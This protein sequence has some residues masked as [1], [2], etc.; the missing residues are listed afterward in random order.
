[1]CFLIGVVNTLPPTLAPTYVA[2]APTPGPTI[3]PSTMP[4]VMPTLAP[5]YNGIDPTPVPTWA[6]SVVPTFIPTAAAIPVPTPEPTYRCP[7]N[8]FGDGLTCSCQSSYG[9][10]GVGSYT[11]CTLCEIGKTF[12]V[13]MNDGI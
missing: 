1:M 9:Q 7:T 6:P 2:S 5:T 13:Y 4:T 10:V 3:C 11:Y 12:L 8:S